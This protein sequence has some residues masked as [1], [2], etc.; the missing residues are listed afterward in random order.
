[1]R[2]HTVSRLAL[3]LTVAAGL[4]L[5]GCPK[6]DT[7]SDGVGAAEVGPP[8]AVIQQT[9]PAPVPT[10][11]MTPFTFDQSGS[12]IGFVGKKITGSHAGGWK[13]FSGTVH[14]PATGGVAGGQVKATIAMASTFS[15]SE[16]LTGHLRSPDFFDAAQFP[17]TTFISTG[18]APIAGSADFYDVTGNLTFH[19]V[20]KGVRFPATIAVAGDT[21]TVK[22]N[23]LLD[24][25]A[26]GV[27]YPG[28]PDDLI[29]DDVELTFNLVAK[30]AAAP[31]GDAPAG[32]AA[33]AD[34]ATDGAAP[35]E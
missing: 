16:K 5:F 4:S 28:K 18:V 9:A 24:R 31:A 25:K 32:D 15:D 8:R 14:L 3:T 33:P 23:F 12:S 35:T 6:K 19:G 27:V 22:A 1:M 11:E 13:T 29:K 2:T 30:K 34:A 10:P 26:F 17:E 7:A 21:V 20:E